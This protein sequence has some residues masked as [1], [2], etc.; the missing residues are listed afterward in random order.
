[1]SA[2]PR[3]NSAVTFSAQA[4]AHASVCASYV[5]V[6]N[7]FGT[8]PPLNPL[9]GR[10]RSCG[11]RSGSWNGTTSA[12]DAAMRRVRLSLI[13]SR[14]RRT[15]GPARMRRW[16]PRATNP[17]ITGMSRGM[18]PPP[19]NMAA[20]I[21]ARRFTRFPPSVLQPGIVRKKDDVVRSPPAVDGTEAA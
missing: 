7:C 21:C 19:W 16:W 18:F 11:W 5:M 1:M 17:A 14:D 2:G 9:G 6:W 10:K 13:G 12:P 4:D 15:P 3:R 20:R 8:H